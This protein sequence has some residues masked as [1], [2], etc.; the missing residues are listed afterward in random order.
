M[1]FSFMYLISS[2]F[3][4]WAHRLSKTQSLS[5]WPTPAE[6]R[7]D[8]KC[9][10][11]EPDC[12]GPP[13]P[14]FGHAEPRVYAADLLKRRVKSPRCLMARTRHRACDPPRLAIWPAP[15]REL[16]ST[17]SQ[18][19]SSPGRGLRKYSRDSPAAKARR[20]DAR[21]ASPKIER[22]VQAAL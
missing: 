9:R 15:P 5:L 20:P 13:N 3:D 4:F 14:T 6:Y 8:S 17:T 19:M 18:S 1:M 2:M 11:R 10:G 12:R 16:A 7:F 22:R 21:Q